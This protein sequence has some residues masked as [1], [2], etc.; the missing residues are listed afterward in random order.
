MI[1]SWAP[2]A[3]GGPNPFDIFL[4]DPLAFLSSEL[5]S[6]AIHM[7]GVTLDH[8]PLEPATPLGTQIGVDVGIAGDVVQIPRSFAESLAAQGFPVSGFTFFPNLRQLNVHKGL[9]QSIDIGGSYLSMLGILIWAVDLKVVLYQPEEGVTWAV[10]LSR[11]SVN[12]P[13]GS[14]DLSGASASLSMETVTWT[15]ALLISRKMSFADPYLGVGYQFVN[16]NVNLTATSNGQVSVPDINST[17][18]STGSNFLAFL[19]L[20]MRVPNLGLRITLEGEY[21]AKGYHA[22]SSK[23]GFSF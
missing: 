2:A 16:G 21:S 15:P 6:A 10:R 4:S 14:A 5:A 1:V 8:R 12:I 3:H 11:N 17:V 18:S 7:V 22:L 13:I 9:S 23:I 20:S 19:G